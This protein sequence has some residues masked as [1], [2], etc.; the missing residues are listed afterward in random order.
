VLVGLTLADPN[1]AWPASYTMVTAVDIDAD[2]AP[3]ITGIP[4]SGGGY[5]Q[6]PVATAIL[7][8][9]AKADKIYLASRTAVALT[10]T[11][12]SCT[13]QAGTVTVKFFDNHIVGCHVA[14]GD[15]CTTAQVDFVD[16][17]RTTFTVSGG[18]FTSKV[19]ADD[20]TCTTARA[21]MGGKP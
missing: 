12:T 5:V 19:I 1:S 2:G 15:A 21:A 17:N 16:T 11:V 20:A 8:L 18:T 14:G 4:R 9:G 10:G 3:G 7:G 6:P 13:E